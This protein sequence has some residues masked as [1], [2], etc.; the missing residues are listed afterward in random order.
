LGAYGS[1]SMSWR[2]LAGLV[3]EVREGD[4]Q[5]SHS[6]LRGQ[7]RRAASGEW[8]SP[9]WQLVCQLGIG[10]GNSFDFSNVVELELISKK[11]SCTVTFR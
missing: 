1:L 11:W 5:D 2:G 9:F 10:V 3:I 7:G 8:W 6:G 4:V